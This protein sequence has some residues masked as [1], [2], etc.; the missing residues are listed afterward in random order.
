MNADSVD[1]Q[2]EITEERTACSQSR[3][4]KCT[5]EFPSHFSQHYQGFSLPNMLTVKDS[6]TNV[7][8]C[9]VRL[10]KWEHTQVSYFLERPTLS[11]S[12][13]RTE[14][15]VARLSHLEYPQT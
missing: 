1:S 12:Q 13:A 4:M 6:Y 15:S 10:K 14:T 11:D 2:C 3:P 7:I 5:T 8:H 9:N